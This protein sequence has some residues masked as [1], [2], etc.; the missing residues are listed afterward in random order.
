MKKFFLIYF[1]LF[2]FSIYIISEVFGK[3][4]IVF[5]K[6]FIFLKDFWDFFSLFIFL[7]ILYRKFIKKSSNFR[8][9]FKKILKKISHNWKK[10]EARPGRPNRCSPSRHKRK[11]SRTTVRKS[12]RKGGK[13]QISVYFV[14]VI[15]LYHFFIYLSS[16]FRIFIISFSS[17][18]FPV[19]FVL[20]FSSS[21]NKIPLGK[22]TTFC[23]GVP[24]DTI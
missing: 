1:F 16:D 10:L 15:I 13:E 14:F 19:Q 2:P 24:Y 17:N 11:N 3:V 6:L 7:N 20:F 23:F 18:A 8:K 21:S 5:K 4:K 12:L 22:S 9:K